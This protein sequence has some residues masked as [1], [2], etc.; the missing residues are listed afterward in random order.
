MRC[1]CW[2]KWGKRE[3]LM[4]LLFAV[5]CAGLIW[6]LFLRRIGT[7]PGAEM[8]NFRLLHTVRRFVRAYE[9]STDPSLRL[10]ILAN[11]VGNLVLFLPMG[12]F[13]PAI[14]PK[15]RPFYLTL[16]VL[17]L[18]IGLTEVVQGVTGLGVCDVDDGLLNACGGIIGWSAW[19][20]WP[21][22]RTKISE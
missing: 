11:L 6:L 17:F 9:N 1:V 21:R 18:L 7:E 5:Y 20:C 10:Y 19:R 12:I 13:L 14:F 8:F 4:P 2:K 22:E 3:D 15:I 16:P